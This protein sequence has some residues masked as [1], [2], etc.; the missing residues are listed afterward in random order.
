MLRGTLVVVGGVEELTDE[1]ENG[2]AQPPE[3]GVS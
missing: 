3:A 1:R 2:C